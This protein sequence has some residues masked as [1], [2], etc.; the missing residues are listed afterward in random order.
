MPD[1]LT[2]ERRSWNMGRIRAR[3]TA[4]E[5]AVRRAAHALGYRFRLHRRDLPGCPDVVF[6]RHRLALMVHGCFWH[7]HPDPACK[8]ARPPKSNQGYWLEKLSRNLDRDRAAAEALVALGW[9]VAVV[10]ECRTRNGEQLRERLRTIIEP[11]A[12]GTNEN[13]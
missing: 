2:P 1:K 9:R 3:D 13:G 12:A 4:P 10:W 11:T 8:D 6:P 5:L 7:Q